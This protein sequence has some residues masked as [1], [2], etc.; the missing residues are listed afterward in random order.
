MN[1]EL[2]E[3]LTT[4]TQID[5]K[6]SLVGLDRPTDF[7]ERQSALHAFGSAVEIAKKAIN[8]VGI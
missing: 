7:A 2:I 4:I 1:Q 5:W 8:N 3:A 6:K